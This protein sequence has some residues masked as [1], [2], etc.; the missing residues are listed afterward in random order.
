MFV[1]LVKDYL[2]KLEAV[3]QRLAVSLDRDEIQTLGLKLRFYFN[4]IRHYQ[5]MMDEVYNRVIDIQEK[6]GFV[7]EGERRQSSE[8]KPQQDKSEKTEDLKGLLSD[9]I[10]RMEEKGIDPKSFLQGAPPVKEPEE[11]MPEVASAPEAEPE[12]PEPATPPAREQVV[13]EQP[14]PEE[15]ELEPVPEPNAVSSAGGYQRDA[16]EMY[17]K[18]QPDMKGE[19]PESKIDL[20]NAGVEPD[21]VPEDDTEAWWPPADEEVS[22]EKSK[23]KPQAEAAGEFDEID[24]EPLLTPEELALVAE[25]MEDEE[26]QPAEVSQPAIS[27]LVITAEPEMKQPVEPPT[28]PVEYAQE[29]APEEQVEVVEEQIIPAGPKSIAERVAEWAAAIG[30]A[31]ISVEEIES[32]MNDLLEESDVKDIESLL[33]AVENGFIQGLPE[34]DAAAAGFCAAYILKLKGRTGTAINVLETAARKGPVFSEFEILLGDLYFS[35]SLYAGALEAYTG[36]R[37]RNSELGHSW[38]RMIVCMRETGNW[39]ALIA[40]LNSL[41]S[42][43]SPELTLMKAEAL[44]NKGRISESLKVSQAMFD[45]AE[46]PED[47]VKSAVFSAKAL[48]AKGDI[49]GAMDSYERCFQLG[50]SAPEAHFELGRL[51]LQHKAIPLGKNQLMTIMKKYPESGWADKAR[52]LMVKEGVY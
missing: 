8:K 51:Y 27:A 30:A 38:E 6:Y 50:I 41:P 4:E 42:G 43:V 7:A 22:A 28:A 18:L 14:L 21:F 36:A 40:E 9:W 32:E 37:A 16:L 12:E 48:E 24:E 3:E 49:L 23:T 19:Q 26:I 33:G 35:R 2:K 5:R 1:H 15:R 11:K 25:T 52:D 10:S 39:D 17:R 44:L 31:Q 20:I 47:K 46:T 45:S 34:S 29:P 13:E